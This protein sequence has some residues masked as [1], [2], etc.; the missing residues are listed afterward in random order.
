MTINLKNH[1]TF[2]PPAPKPVSLRDTPPEPVRETVRTEARMRPRARAER[3]VLY[4]A[5]AL[6]ALLAIVA[7]VLAFSKSSLFVSD[8]PV[9]LAK[10]VGELML[11]PEDETPTVATVS[12]MHALE[13]QVFFKNAQ[14]GDKVLMYLASQRAILYRPSE[15]LIIEV[16]PITGATE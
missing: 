5:L 16:G 7:G 10:Q 9:S 15:R 2:S 3:S 4:A 11:L 1:Q 14:V 8:D 6:V 12:D 13:G